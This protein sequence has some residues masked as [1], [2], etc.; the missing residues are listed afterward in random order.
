[1]SHDIVA[2]ALNQVM[3]AK[4]SGKNKVTLK[5]HSKFLL[6]VFAV[7]KLKGYIKEY[8]VNGKDLT[9][10]FGKV[11]FCKAIKPRYLVKSM[12]IDKYIRRYLPGRGMGMLIIST[13]RGL[14]THQ[15]A[16]DKKL[17]GSLIAY[18]Y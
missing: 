10:E 7:G 9:I 15:T 2:D 12:N 17:G 13:S 14:M 11:N 1:M 3:N 4:K 5:H 16:L 8:H 6:N 18:F